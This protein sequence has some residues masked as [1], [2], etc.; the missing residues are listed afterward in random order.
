MNETSILFPN[1]NLAFSHVGK[2][3]Q[4]GGFEIA[5]YGIII[6]VGMVLGILLILKIADRT[7]QD[8]D[9]YMDL[10]LITI[11][12]A[13][14]G[15][16]IYYV[17]FSWEDYRENLLEI[18][19]LRGGGLAIY[20]GVLAG[21][22]TVWIF[23]R[24]RKVSFLR[25][26]DT[27][28]PG[29]A[30]GQIIGRWG[31]FFNREAFGGYTDGLLAMALPRN[32]VRQGEIT[33]QMLEHLQTISGVEFI[34]VHPTFLYESLWNIGVLLVLLMVLK[35]KK[36]DGQMFWIYLLG[37]GLGRCWIEG[38]RTDQLLM[39]GVGMPVSQVLSVALVLLALLIMGTCSRGYAGKKRGETNEQNGRSEEK[40]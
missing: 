26:A 12:C 31:N 14:V 18:F 23:S 17:V 7:G 28:I 27:V 19:N 10:C 16:R 36:Y 25:L 24:V 32:A 38:L 5:Y 40:N 11:V 33:G 4:I 34:Q 21:V 3:V 35:K 30:L 13:V 22:L 1:L 39:P 6:A 9:L 15:A 37:Y 29:L 8:A 2:S 20:G